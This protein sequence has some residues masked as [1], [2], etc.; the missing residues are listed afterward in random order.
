M[1]KHCYLCKNFGLSKGCSINSCNEFQFS[2]EALEIFGEIKEDIVNNLNPTDEMESEI[3][4]MINDTV[5]K[6]S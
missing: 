5:G 1:K 3:A 4:N 6:V 2:K